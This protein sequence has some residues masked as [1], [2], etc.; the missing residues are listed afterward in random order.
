MD[1]C[2]TYQHKSGSRKRKERA[3]RLESIKQ[4]QTLLSKFFVTH[5]DHSS[6]NTVDTIVSQ[7]PDAGLTDASDSATTVTAES[8]HENVGDMPQNSSPTM[9]TSYASILSD[10]SDIPLLESESSDV[11]VSV[12]DSNMTE[13]VPISVGQLH[14]FDIGQVEEV[15]PTP[16]QVNAAVRTGHLQHPSNFPPDETGRAFPQTLLHIQL[17]NGEKIVRDWLV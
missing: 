15:I 7:L 6:S 14:E 10:Q 11:S 16:N 1:R 9:A 12:P 17:N 8:D 2:Q 13:N 3:A 4:G 5:G